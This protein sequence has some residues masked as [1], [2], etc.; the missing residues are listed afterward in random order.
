MRIAALRNVPDL[1][2]SRYRCI[3]SVR[4]LVS[5]PGFA[6]KMGTISENISHYSHI[7]EIVNEGQWQPSKEPE[8]AKPTKR[9]GVVY[10]RRRVGD[11]GAK[12]QPER[13]VTV[14][15]V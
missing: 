12:V 14:R 10:D 5:Y 6:T 8:V 4:S 15:E 2:E 7:M 9:H 13:L 11:E 3:I 1:T